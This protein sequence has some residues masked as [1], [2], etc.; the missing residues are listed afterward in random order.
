MLKS[1][2]VQR[3]L[4]MSYKADLTQTKI[5][6]VLLKWILMWGIEL[7]KTFFSTGILS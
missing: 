1:L 3:S 6:S 5:K 7:L 4:E 2:K